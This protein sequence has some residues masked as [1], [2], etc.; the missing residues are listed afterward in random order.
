MRDWR[1]VAVWL[2]YWLPPLGYMGA[3]FYFS[4]RPLPEEVPLVE[5]DWGDKLGHL[6][7]YGGLGVLLWRAF[8]GATAVARTAAPWWAAGVGTLYGLSDELHQA[9]VPFRRGEVGDWVAD[10]LG[11]A[12]AVLVLE[13]YRGNT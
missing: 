9:L 3:I 10:A 6:L 1:R 2:R 4:G 7:L 13:R 12:I 8:V 11:I 5:L